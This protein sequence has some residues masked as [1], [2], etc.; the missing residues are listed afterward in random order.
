MKE[1]HSQAPRGPVFEALDMSVT[2]ALRYLKGGFEAPVRDAIAQHV[3]HDNAAQI[4]LAAARALQLQGQHV[5]SWHME[6]EE[7]ARALIDEAT[8]AA[9]LDGALAPAEAAA[10]EAQLAGSQTM[11][12]QMAETAWETTTPVPEGMAAPV[13]HVSAQKRLDEPEL[14]QQAEFKPSWWAQARKWFEAA[15]GQAWRGPAIGFALGALAM[16]AVFG[17]WPQPDT[18]VILPGAFQAD[19]TGIM[20]SGDVEA[21]LP[22]LELP[23]GQE[24]R[25]QWA[26]V[27][28]AEYTVEAMQHGEV[29]H[30]ETVADNVWSLAN[31]S[32]AADADIT[33]SVQATF[34]TG[35]VMPVT[36]VQIVWVK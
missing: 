21:S 30:T 10:V 5:M 23:M 20:M 17:G 11:Y 33:L 27:E 25:L 8:M 18:L 35:G 2:D 13:A 32:L 12:R 29:V 28:G 19:D 22:V 4:E 24:A 16:F 15:I 1:D 26:E 31:A 34:A 9:Y 3:E 7:T 6:D 14:M 36:S